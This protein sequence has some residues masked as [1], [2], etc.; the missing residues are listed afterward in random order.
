MSAAESEWEHVSQRVECCEC[1]A[2]SGYA[3][4]GACPVCESGQIVRIIRRAR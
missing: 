4:D 1:E 3:V 2:V